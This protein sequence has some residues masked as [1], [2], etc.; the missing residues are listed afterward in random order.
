MDELELLLIRQHSPQKNG[1]CAALP[2]S[3]DLKMWVIFRKSQ[4]SP[5]SELHTYSV[6]G[7]RIWGRKSDCNKRSYRSRGFPHSLSCHQT[8]KR[9]AALNNGVWLA[10]PDLQQE[11]DWCFT[12]T[13][14]VWHKCLLWPTLSWK[15]TRKGILESVVAAQLNWH[16]SVVYKDSVNSCKVT[17]ELLF[18]CLH[19]AFI[20]VALC[21]L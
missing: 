18:I 20:C 17:T 12:S 10:C 13:F 3:L 6:Q 15:Q 21:S 14:E 4:Y 16:R 2:P 5:P 1:T 7:R 8:N 19:D 9:S 11:H